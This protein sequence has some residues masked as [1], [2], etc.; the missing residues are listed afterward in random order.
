[1]KEK[2]ILHCDMNNFY[3]SVE[4]LERPDL[5]NK[6]VAVS[7]NPKKRHGII[8]AKNQI[9]KAQGVNTAETIWQA[10][11]K[12]PDLVLLPPH[13]SKYKHYSKLIN[14]IYLEY[15]DMVEP[16]S[17]DESWLDVTGSLKL[18]GGGKTIADTIRHRIFKELGLMLSAGVSFNKIFAKM[19]SEYKKPFCTT[20][21]SRENFKKILWP[22]KVG[23]LFGIGK[24]SGDKLNAAGIHTIGDLAKAPETVISFLLGKTGLISKHNAMGLNDDPVSDFF[25]IDNLKSLSHG[26]TFTRNLK[27][28]EDIKTALK[29]LSD[30]VAFR[31]RKHCLQGSVIKIYIKNTEFET[32]SRQ[33]KISFNTNLSKDIYDVALALL[34]EHWDIKI[35]IRLLTVT[36]A[37]LTKEKDYIQLTLFDNDRS[38]QDLEK[39]IDDIRNAYGSD[40]ITYGSIIDNDLGVSTNYHLLE[41]DDDDR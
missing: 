26:I 9:A 27:S 4:L 16:F 7:G 11:K 24:A 25:E 19:G 38:Q 37:D 10:K 15:T 17:I 29:G 12:C 5:K 34:K 18:F 14:R 41:E 39:T 35:P 31:L 20:V 1:M 30:K 3:A 6:P 33:K 40:S 21:I 36:V 32:I 23:Q 22:M 8:L 2:V 28:E 13:M